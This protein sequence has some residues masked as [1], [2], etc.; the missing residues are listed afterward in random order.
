LPQFTEFMD[1]LSRLLAQAGP[2]LGVVIGF[3]LSLWA[4][5][6]GRVY[7][8]VSAGRLYGMEPDRSGGFAF[9]PIGPRPISNVCELELSLINAK[10]LGIVVTKIGLAWKK[11]LKTERL[12]PASVVDP[13]EPG[14]SGGGEAGRG[15]G[16]IGSRA[17]AGGGSG[18]RIVNVRERQGQRLV[19]KFY[20]TYGQAAELEGA[21]VVWVVGVIGGRRQRKLGS[22]RPAEVFRARATRV[23][24]AG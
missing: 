22:F 13:T 4:S 3:V 8:I 6:R 18:L 16:R 21:S 24:T 7:A 14:A 10:P 15:G 12:W 9:G 1:W 23:S 20:P 17:R 19:L 5:Q 11:G 2:V